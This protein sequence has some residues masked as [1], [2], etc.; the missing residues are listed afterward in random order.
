M[1]RRRKRSRRKAHGGSILKKDKDLGMSSRQGGEEE[2]KHRQQK[3]GK[4]KQKRRIAKIVKD[5][6][7]T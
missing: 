5:I 2:I 1:I 4:W 3:G 7:Q 6:P